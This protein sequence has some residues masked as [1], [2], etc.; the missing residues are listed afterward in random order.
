MAFIK[1][2]TEIKNTF[3]SAIIYSSLNFRT[4][5]PDFYPASYRILSTM[6]LFLSNDNT[7]HPRFSGPRLTGRVQQGGTFNYLV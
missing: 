3:N 4:Y 7:V 5:V 2:D 6:I 1:V